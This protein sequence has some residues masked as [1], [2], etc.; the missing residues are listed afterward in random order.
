MGG[1][2]QGGSG[3]GVVGTSGAGGQAGQTA[4]GCRAG[5]GRCSAGNPQLCTSGG[6]WQAASA[7]PSEKPV[8]RVGACVSRKFLALGAQHTCVVGEAG[9]VAC[10][11]SG[12]ATGKAGT[13]P[14][15]GGTGMPTLDLGTGATALTLAAA[16]NSTCALL[17]SGGKVKCW[18]MSSLGELGQ[19]DMNTRGD[20]PGEL[21]DNLP[22]VDLG[23]GAVVVGISGSFAHFCVLLDDGRV[24]CW[25][26]NADGELGLTDFANRGDTPNEMGDRLAAVDLGAGHSVRSVDVGGLHSCVLLDEG[27]VK[28]WGGHQYGQLGLGYIPTNRTEPDPIGDAW[29]AV[30]LGT[31]RTARAIAGGDEHTC[32]LLDGGDVKCWGQNEYGQLGQGDTKDRGGAPTD[33]GDNL[34]P[35][36]LGTGRKAVALTAGGGNTCVLLDN[37]Q[38]KCWGYN[39]HGQLGLGDT[40]ARGDGPGEMGDNLPAIDLGTGRTAVLIVP[41]GGHTCAVLDDGTVKC[42]GYNTTGQLGLSMAVGGSQRGT[43]PGQM[44][45]NLPTVDVG[46]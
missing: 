29:P 43:A 20:D 31:G 18:G 41:G 8:C 46:F 19:G 42:W 24:K 25:G 36:D 32:A 33:L 15:D 7:C 13:N 9:Q 38:A 5:E 1:G 34:P 35:V 23:A 40:Q 27:K 3:G 28:C 30:A 10:W 14:L 4:L 2:A 12:V 39:N 6:V 37:G 21:G 26:D 44:G 45:D 17:A 16:S 22:P 11:G